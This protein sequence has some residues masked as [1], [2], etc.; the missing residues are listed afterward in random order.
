M[1]IKQATD[2]FIW[3]HQFGK[4][5]E[6]VLE[7][8]SKLYAISL[9]SASRIAAGRRLPTSIKTWLVE[10]SDSELGLVPRDQH[11]NRITSSAVRTSLTTRS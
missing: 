8:R 4:I 9:A 1:P 3:V 5:P 6:G 2:Q 7:L 11:S 10:I